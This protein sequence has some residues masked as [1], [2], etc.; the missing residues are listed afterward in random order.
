ML[1][2]GRLEVVVPPDYLPEETSGD[3]MVPEGGNVVL[4]CRAIGRPHPNVTWRREDGIELLLQDHTGHKSPG[5]RVTLTA[6]ILMI[7]Q[8]ADHD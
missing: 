4:T 6:A 1:Q 3:T 2:I 5:K 8:N 7:S